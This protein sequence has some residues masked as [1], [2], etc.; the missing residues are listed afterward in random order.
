MCYF[1]T[2]APLSEFD[3][4]NDDG[5]WGDDLIQAWDDSE[6]TQHER[7][8]TVVSDTDPEELPVYQEAVGGETTTSS[9]EIF[10]NGDGGDGGQEIIERLDQISSDFTNYREE[11]HQERLMRRRNK[12]ELDTFKRVIK[13]AVSNNN[14]A[15]KEVIARQKLLSKAVKQILDNQAQSVIL[16]NELINMLRRRSGE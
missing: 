13:E 6:F 2:L 12:R 15:V 7:A 1:Y 8:V 5:A 11:Q 14:V 16:F 3:G 10:R 9:P 4:Q